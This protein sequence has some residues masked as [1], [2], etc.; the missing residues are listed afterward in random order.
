MHERPG[1]GGAL[2]LAARHLLRIVAEAMADAHAIGQSRRARFG[3]FHGHAAQQTGQGDVV[4]NREGGQQVE[5]LEDEA[6]AVAPQAGEGVVVER[7]EVAPLDR[8]A[9]RRRAV[10][11]PAQMQQRRLTAPRGAH[12]R[13]EIAGLQGE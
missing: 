3:I 12:Q 2:C 8:E 5:E 6:D 1:D 9:S 7:A 13:H 4:A 11:G 10:H